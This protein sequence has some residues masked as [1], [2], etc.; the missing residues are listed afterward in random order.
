[1]DS[2]DPDRPQ[3]HE[4]EGDAPEPPPSAPPRL[5]RSRTDRVIGGV[6]GGLG[7]HF[8]IDPVILRIVAVV[9]LFFGG[10]SAV[11]YLAAL[12]FVPNE[13]LEGE[14]HS[15]PASER[16]RALVIVAIVA[17][18]VVGWPLLLGGGLAIAGVA[19]PLAVLALVGLLVWWLVSG[20]GASGSAGDVARRAALGVGVLIVCLAI[21]AGGAWAA[22]VGGA[23]VA[24]GLVIAAG[25]TLVVGA[26]AGG[27]RVLLLPALA[28]ALGVGFVSAANIDLR[29]GVGQREYRPAS[30]ADVQDRYRIGMGEL[31]VDLRDA[32][33]PRGDTP[34]KLQVGVGHALVLVPRDVCVASSA[35]VGMGA[36]DVFDRDNGG[37]DVAWAD[38]PPAR[39]GASRVVVDADVGLGL[40][41]VA[42]Q[43]GERDLRF[44][45][46]FH[47]RD[48]GDRNEGC[49][50]SARA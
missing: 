45:P 49:G 46:R 4:P 14:P 37:I 6:C 33:L 38:R 34:L 48:D 30:A 9:L 44:G 39:E 23:A 25:L 8:G 41:E 11:A 3:S 28:L 15:Q 27:L 29:G 40:F 31:V 18:V 26:F 16:N 24:A 21:F 35:D 32:K 17:L 22:G 12:L 19:V 43:R 2:Q 50:R 7:R 36:V 1:M 5:Y 42:H 13:P 10:A 20:E 47:H